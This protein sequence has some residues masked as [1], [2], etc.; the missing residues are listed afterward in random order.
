MT[1]APNTDPVPDP[2]PADETPE[3]QPA[4]LPLSWPDR[5]VPAIPESPAADEG[6]QDPDA[7]EQP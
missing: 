3:Q 1:D 7:G 4:T 6:V 2:E 5:V